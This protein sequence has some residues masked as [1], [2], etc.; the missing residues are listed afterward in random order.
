MIDDLHSEIEKLKQGFEQFK[1]LILEI[2]QKLQLCQVDIDALQSLIPA[3]DAL[4]FD[5]CR[6]NDEDEEK[7]HIFSLREDL[8][9]KSNKTDLVQLKTYFDHQMRKILELNK[10]NAKDLERLKLMKTATCQARQIQTILSTD[11]STRSMKK[12]KHRMHSYQSSR[13]Y[14]TFDLD[15]IRKYQRQ[16]LMQSPYGTIPLYR[17]QAWVEEI[18]SK[19]RLKE[20]EIFSDQ[21]QQRTY[22]QIEH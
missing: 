11:E 9:K 3:I 13:P 12:M 8:A 15:D 21:R 7:L 10:S 22:F 1:S 14:I 20:I 17:R 19:K 18:R 5:A 16:A 4:P 2:P 6:F